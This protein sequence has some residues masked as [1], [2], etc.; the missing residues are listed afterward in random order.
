MTSEYS[1]IGWLTNT[2]NWVLIQYVD[3]MR[4]RPLHN[5]R[6]HLHLV[7][8]IVARERSLIDSFVAAGRQEFNDKDHKSTGCQLY[9]SVLLLSLSESLIVFLCLSVSLLLITPLC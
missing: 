6:S 5:C 3:T 8:E 9:G 1:L 7:D 2:T 4:R